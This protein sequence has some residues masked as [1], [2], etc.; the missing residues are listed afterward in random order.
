MSPGSPVYRRPRLLAPGPD[1]D[2]GPG[3]AGRTIPTNAEA[4]LR[5]AALQRL[6]S[7]ILR[8]TSLTAE[9]H[10]LAPAQGHGSLSL[11][12]DARP[13]GPFPRVP[14]HLHPA[15]NA[16]AIPGRAFAQAVASFGVRY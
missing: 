9:P 15:G 7:R 4:Y 1:R 11:R 10:A 3:A 13:A 2:C 14:A 12:G 16:A 6:L 5:F 8:F